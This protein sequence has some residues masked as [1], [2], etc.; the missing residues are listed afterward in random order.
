MCEPGDDLLMTL[1]SRAERATAEKVEADA[2]AERAEA[3]VDALDKDV[4]D[5]ISDL[6]D[7]R[8][9]ADQLAEALRRRLDGDATAG[10]AALAT[11]DEA[12]RPTT[13]RNDE[14]SDHA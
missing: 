5:Y 13:T 11:Y 14:E 2:R 7:E 3:T 10:H 1:L 6:V 8:A 12:R 4:A 9:L